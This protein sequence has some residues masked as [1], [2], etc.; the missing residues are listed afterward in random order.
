[1]EKDMA[2]AQHWYQRS[3][4]QG[5][6]DAQ[7]DLG[8]ISEVVAVAETMRA[9]PFTAVAQDPEDAVEWFELS[10]ERGNAKGQFNLAECYY[11]RAVAARLCLALMP[12]FSMEME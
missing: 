11:V 4:E 10:A 6:A 9:L 12:L 5:N 2:R 3:A 8:V 7:N 1:V